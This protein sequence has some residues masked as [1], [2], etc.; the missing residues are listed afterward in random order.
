MISPED[1][2]NNEVRRVDQENINKFARLNARLHEVRREKAQLK[3]RC[4]CRCSCRRLC[5]RWSERD[6]WT[7]ESKNTRRLIVCLPLVF[8]QK[9]L[10]H[11]DDASTELMMGSG[12]KVMLLLGDSFFE[13]KEDAATDFCE[14]QV[15][16]LQAAV[17]RLEDEQ[18]QILAKQDEYKA[19]L[20]GRFGKS[21]NLEEDSAD[22]GEK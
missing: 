9:E 2:N 14:A 15:E 21:I 5:G 8:W 7:D 22:K 1:E 6:E 16:K 20:Y 3:V 18:K 11:L 13:T 4:R 17:T 12:D 10:E 19:L